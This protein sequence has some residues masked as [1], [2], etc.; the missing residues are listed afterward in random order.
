MP[1][2]TFDRDHLDE[3]F[4]Y[5]ARRGEVGCLANDV[6]VITDALYELLQ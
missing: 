2:I 4:M 6:F 5:V 3:G 1:I